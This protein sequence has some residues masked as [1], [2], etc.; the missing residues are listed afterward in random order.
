V[1]IA[2]CNK[3]GGN[4]SS[5]QGLDFGESVYFDP[6]L[7]VKSD[8]TILTKILQFEFSDF[9][10]EQAA[11]LRLQFT[12]N[13]GNKIDN[14]I[15]TVYDDGELLIDGIIRINADSTTVRKEIGIQFPPKMD[16]GDYHGYLVVIEHNFDRIDSFDKN[17]IDNTDNRIKQWSAHYEKDWNPLALFLFWILILLIATLF[18]WFAVLR[19]QIYSKMKRGK[20]VINSPYYKTI[21]IKNARRLVL[22]TQQQ[23]QKVLYKIFAGNILYEVNTIWKSEIVLTPGRKNTLRIKLGMDYTINPFTTTLRRGSSYEIKKQ[24]EIIKISYL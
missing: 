23:K 1:V 2:S 3:K 20:I 15:I 10:V 8:T 24:N 13:D 5:L 12:D 22:T 7:W 11:Y 21:K 16:A 17:Q 6:F 19:N 18:L 14:N 9:A 4:E